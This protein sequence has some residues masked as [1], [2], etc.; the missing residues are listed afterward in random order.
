[1]SDVQQVDWSSFRVT[2]NGAYG[3]GSDLEHHRD[4]C[5]WNSGIDDLNPLEISE[6]ATAHAAVCTG[7]PIPPKV[8]GS[9]FARGGLLPDVW[10]DQIMAT[11]S[12]NCYLLSNVSGPGKG[13]DGAGS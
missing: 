13:A 3:G 5:D 6:L 12:R 7:L 2:N 1:M 8:S 10:G 11:L 9:G 4:R